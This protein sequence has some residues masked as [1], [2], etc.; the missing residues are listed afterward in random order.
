MAFSTHVRS[1]VPRTSNINQAEFSTTLKSHTINDMAKPICSE[2]EVAAGIKK[3]MQ[4]GIGQWN[5]GNTAEEDEDEFKEWNQAPTVD[6]YLNPS[7]LKHR[8]RTLYLWG[9]YLKKSA[10][11]KEK[12]L[13]M[14]WH[15]NT[16][17]IAWLGFLEFL[18]RRYSTFAPV[19]PL[20]TTSQVLNCKP[21]DKRQKYIKSETLNQHCIYFIHAIWAY[22]W[23]YDNE[24]RPR[25]CGMVFITQ[26]Q[27]PMHL[28]NKVLARTSVSPSSRWRIYSWAL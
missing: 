16:V 11:T 22:T 14:H 6:E 17:D 18:V 15:L 10:R 20:L 28:K 25:P 13:A 9:A 19:L 8:K 7:A 4:R 23:D 5:A 1:D 3:I 21:K 24:G 26:T 27:S 12:I 2:E